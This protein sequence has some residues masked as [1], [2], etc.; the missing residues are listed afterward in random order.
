MTHFRNILVN[1][2]NHP[3]LSQYLALRISPY[4]AV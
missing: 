3:Y 2:K 1:P 4:L